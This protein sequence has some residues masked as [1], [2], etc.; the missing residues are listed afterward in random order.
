MFYIDIRTDRENGVTLNKQKEWLKENDITDVKH[1]K[2][3][4]RMQLHVLASIQYNRWRFQDETDLMAF[5][6]RWI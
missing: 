2:T 5:K 1:I 4:S 3:D 6:L